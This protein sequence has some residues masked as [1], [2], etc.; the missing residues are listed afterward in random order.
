MALFEQNRTLWIVFY[1]FVALALFAGIYL[2]VLS[3]QSAPQRVVENKPSTEGQ[4]T[5]LE[6]TYVCLPRTDNS[7]A[8]ECTPGLKVG[9]DYYALDLALL[10]G[11]GTVT[12]FSNG[13]KILAAGEI[14]PVEEISS[15]QWDI[16]PVRV[17]CAL[18][19]LLRTNLSTVNA[20]AHEASVN[21]AV[22]S[23]HAL[24]QGNEVD[25]FE[26]LKNDRRRDR[27]CD[28]RVVHLFVH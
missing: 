18:L 9:E 16:Y 2:A 1:V 21:R 24:L 23:L 6:G 5:V 8:S 17:S 12:N 14:V 25:A 13:T 3:A 19:K 11:S 7:K 28:F 4:A 22:H 27:C 20:I 10:L 26:Y 15:D